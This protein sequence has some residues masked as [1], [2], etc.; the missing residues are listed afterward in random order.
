MLVLLWVETSS[1][2]SYVYIRR[3]A[4]ETPVKWEKLCYYN[5]MVCYYFNKYLYF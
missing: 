3:E 4:A 5:N 1:K 2:G